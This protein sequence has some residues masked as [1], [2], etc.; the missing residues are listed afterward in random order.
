[1][2]LGDIPEHMKT[3]NWVAVV[4]ELA[5]V[6]VGVFLGIQASNWNVERLQARE[7]A[8]FTERLKADLRYELEGWN[9]LVAYLGVV[10]ENANQAAA[11]LEGRVD[12]SDETLLIHAYRATQYMY[13]VRR[14]ATYE[15]LTSTG[16]LGLIGDQ[17][18][19]DTAVQFYLWPAI[20]D[21]FV[22][23]SGSVYRNLFRGII[24]LEVQGALTRD[25]GDRYSYS[26]TFDLTRVDLDFECQTDLSAAQIQAAAAALRAH[27]ELLPSLRLRAVNLGTAISNLTI[28]AASIAQAMAPLAGESP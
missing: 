7:G 16:A 6:V 3:R 19:R 22:E 4:G 28:A 2:I 13:Y 11:I 15:E 20:E 21:A 26:G 18:L 8:Q 27:P 5:I 9:A 17:A 10:R 1:M 25:C 24:P 23:G 12:A 14:R